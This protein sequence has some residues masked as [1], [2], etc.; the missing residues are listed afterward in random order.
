[1]D[2]AVKLAVDVARVP[3]LTAHQAA[4]LHPADVLGEE[5]KGRLTPG[6]DA[7]LVVL[8]S[9]LGVVATVV[10]GQV[11]YDPSGLL[12]SLGDGAVISPVDSS[13][14][15]NG[16]ALRAQALASSDGAAEPA[17]TP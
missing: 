11:V 17:P 9:K 12:S 10:A 14:E 16:P 7:D 3:L 15:G 6:S 8:D 2:K 1:M 4:S 13:R 5:R